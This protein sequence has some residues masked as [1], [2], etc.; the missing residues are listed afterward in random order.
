MKKFF[1]TATGTEIGKTFITT[2]A[3]HELLTTGKKVMALKPVI[4]GYDKN[5][6]KSDTS[7]ILQALNLEN[8]D[9]NIGMIS[10]YRFT[11]PLSPNM[12]AEKEGK[13][14]NFLELVN[15]IKN[16]EEKDFNFLLAEGA[17]GVMVPINNSFTTL[18]LIEKLSW[19]V[20]LVT[21]SYLGSISHT[22]T[23]AYALYSRNIK[24]GCV[25]INESTKSIVPLN[26]TASTIRNFLK[27]DVLIKTLPRQKINCKN[28]YEIWENT[29]SLAE[30]F[31]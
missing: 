14:I 10:P 20:V 8:N 5:D 2:K 17:G 28:Q 12:A 1:I 18:D 3:C 25:I 29:P 19:E 13:S 7:L 31:A 4:S 23:A 27:E 16:F 22:L 21:G 6:T 26:E 11:A 15:Y 30:C 24:L 9:D